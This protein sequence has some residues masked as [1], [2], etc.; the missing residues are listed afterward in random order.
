MATED[1]EA[2][3]GIRAIIKSQVNIKQYDGKHTEE[4]NLLKRVKNCSNKVQKKVK[5]FIKKSGWWN[6]LTKTKETHSSLKTKK[7]GEIFHFLNCPMDE[8]VEII[9]SKF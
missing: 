8:A 5:K 7:K 1:E 9:N 2:V 6:R 3:I 4:K